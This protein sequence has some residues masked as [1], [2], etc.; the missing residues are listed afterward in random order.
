[1]TL[2][3]C[4]FGEQ[5]PPNASCAA[6]CPAFPDCMPPPSPE[7]LSAIRGFRADGQA[8]SENHEAVAATLEQ[9]HEAITQGLEERGQ[10]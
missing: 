2:Q 9:L 5:L 3:R 1:V 10:P 7:L 8:R 6:L 4:Q